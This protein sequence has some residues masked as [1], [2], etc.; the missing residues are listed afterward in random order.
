MKIFTCMLLV[1]CFLFASCDINTHKSTEEIKDSV[2]LDTI[3][4]KDTKY[5]TKCQ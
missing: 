5:R 4:S 1:L 3:K 2:N